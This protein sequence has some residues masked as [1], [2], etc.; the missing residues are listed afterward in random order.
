MCLAK[1]KTSSAQLRQTSK[2]VLVLV[3]AYPDNLVQTGL[4]FRNGG[5]GFEGGQR[6]WGWAGGLMN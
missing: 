1:N 6:A 4:R 2:G 5:E 3:W